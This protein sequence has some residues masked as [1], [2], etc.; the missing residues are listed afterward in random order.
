LYEG[1]ARE[2]EGSTRVVQGCTR[3]KINMGKRRIEGRGVLGK[4]GER[5]RGG[6]V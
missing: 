6:R 2:Y 5:K 3:G 4:Y 1:C